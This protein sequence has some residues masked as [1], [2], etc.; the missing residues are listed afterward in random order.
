[1]RTQGQSVFFRYER[2]DTLEERLDIARAI[3]A[4]SAALLH[5]TFLFF[6]KKTLFEGSQTA[7]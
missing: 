6:E 7:H 2:A 3:A 1:M 4:E 5:Q